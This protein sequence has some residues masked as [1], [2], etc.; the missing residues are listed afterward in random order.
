[1][2]DMLGATLK[3]YNNE[4]GDITNSEEIKEKCKYYSLPEE[5]IPYLSDEFSILHLNARSLKNKM[6]EFQMF[7]N[8][9]G[10]EW[11][12]ICISETWLKSGVLKYFNIDN[13]ELVAS[14]RKEGEGG[15]TALYI[16]TK[17]CF[18]RRVDMISLN[19]ENIF[20][21]I[22]SKNT[23][24][25][26]NIIIGVIYRPPNVLHTQFIGY[27]EEILSII[28]KEKKAV[29]LAGDFNYDL[30]K[31]M[32]DKN[33][34]SF[35]N[36]LSSYGYISTISKPTRVVRGSST[37]LDNIFVNDHNYVNLSGIIL[38]DLSD[39]F[40]I[41]NLLS[42]KHVNHSEE[43]VRK[44]FDKQ[45]FRELNDFLEVKLANFETI[46][47]PNMACE[48]L[49]NCFI[50]GIEKYSKSFK[51]SRRKTPIKPWI[52]PSILCSINNKNK[53]FRAFIKNR[54]TANENKYKTFR[55]VLTNVLRE[56]KRAYFQ[57]AFEQHKGNGREV[58]KLMREALNSK[59]PSS[60]IPNQ[61]VDESNNVY[62]NNNVAEGFNIFFTSIGQQLESKMPESVADPLTNLR[63]ANYPPFCEPLTTTSLQ[64]ENIIK[65]L[66]Q[67][68]G[69]FDKISTQ[70]LLGTYKRCLA[71][72][73]HFFNLCLHSATFPDL[74]KVAHVIPLFKSGDKSKLTNYRPISLL[75]I[76]SKI[77]E[78]LIHLSIINFL[79]ENEILHE[80][81]FGFRKKRSTFMPV[82]LV[83]EEITK[84]LENH[85]KVLGLYLDLKKAF[86]TV[87]IN[88]LFKKLFHIG[89]RGDLL[90]I[91]KSYFHQRLQ[92]VEV[93]GHVS[94]QSIIKLGVPQGSILGP[95][96][97]IIYINDL[98]YISNVAKFYLFAD[99]TAIILKGNSYEDLQM[100]VNVLIPNISNWFLNNRLS[101]NPSKTFY[102]IYS[103]F[104]NEHNINILLNGTRI[105]RS[106]SVKYL[107]VT[108]DENL[109]WETHINTISS[110]LSSHIG[111]MGR[112]RPYLSSREL[113]MLYNTLVLP[114][115][116]YCAVVWGNNYARH[117]D[118][119]IKLQKRALR[120]I[121]HKPFI[122]PS[123]E[124]FIKYKILKL[125]ELLLE[126][127]VMIILAFLNGTLPHSLS[128]LF[129]INE[130]FITRGHDHFVIPYSHSNFRSFAITFTAPKAWNT[131]IGHLYRNLNDVPRSKL[132]LKKQV[133]TFLVNKYV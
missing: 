79:D 57:N 16:H 83:V 74:L 77:L 4:C 23:M 56:A 103:L 112:M 105:K 25:S 80:S 71:H 20:V 44:V 54:C 106:F 2:A 104:A 125:P 37:L 63:E 109:K 127:N 111:V 88:V 45:K 47:D 12:A 32:Q 91:I 51:P 15:G 89:I 124:L 129:N 121:D 81:Q 27:L 123:N 21:E 31:N 92:Q 85:E 101:L 78:K 76:F 28:D 110:K 122:Y 49:M 8:R 102:Q 14:C 52:T 100:Q 96:L 119:I 94:Q 72:L 98:P 108:L 29:A 128:V 13:Y 126:Q 67:V 118:K 131:T 75:P 65:S 84:A 95:L 73:T 90:K 1:M 62:E 22:E 39:H 58:W 132:I 60:K 115:I 70:I 33:V 107:G 24:P 55:N 11:S 26:K 113:L 133:R 87:N 35:S 6:D 40:P 5:S 36:L 99:D 9:T 114:H 50:E 53:L 117:V 48:T 38:D 69:G 93:Q 59:C 18:K 30:T 7:I 34:L 46:T 19:S 61:I 3:I 130:P 64:I 43:K 17:F 86:D 120:I 66:N 42:L 68:G 41:F 82:A 97:F 10:V 116:N